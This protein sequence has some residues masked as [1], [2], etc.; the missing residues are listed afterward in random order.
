MLY[1]IIDLYNNYWKTNNGKLYLEN[2]LNATTR[3]LSRFTGVP[4]KS[5]FIFAPTVKYRTFN[6]RHVG[7]LSCRPGEIRLFISTDGQYRTWL[8]N[9]G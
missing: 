6:L 5:F 2:T 4:A 7:L 9:L 8:Y 1:W 3:G